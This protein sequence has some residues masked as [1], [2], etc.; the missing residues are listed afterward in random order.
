MRE[1][2]NEKIEIALFEMR[3]LT[4]VSEILETG[5]SL[6]VYNKD[7][8]V[9]IVVDTTNAIPDQAITVYPASLEKV[10]G[11]E[12]LMLLSFISSYHKFKSRL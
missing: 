10:E 8:E 1:E 7:G 2:V 6:V 11:V 4:S 9:A 3:A 5:N 12:E